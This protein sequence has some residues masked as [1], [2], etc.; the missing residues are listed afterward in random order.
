M[1]SQ[2]LGGSNQTNLLLSLVLLPYVAIAEVRSHLNAL[3]H[4]HF[5]FFGAIFLKNFSI[6]IQTYKLQT[7][8]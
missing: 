3:A 2:F 6:L 7:Q 5:L 8:N 4:L 1:A